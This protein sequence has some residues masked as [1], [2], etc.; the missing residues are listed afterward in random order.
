[1]EGRGI[2][3][4]ILSVS[5]FW[6]ACVWHYVCMCIYV[7]RPTIRQVIYAVSVDPTL[8]VCACICN[9][10]YRLVLYPSAYLF[11]V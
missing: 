6:Y 3:Y 10:S 2:Y 4:I 5:W 1:M 11:S 7:Y 9:L 8:N